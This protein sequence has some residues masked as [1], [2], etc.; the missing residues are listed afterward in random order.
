MFAIWFLKRLNNIIC[1][2]WFSELIFQ[3]LISISRDCQQDKIKNDMFFQRHGCRDFLNLSGSTNV[4][5]AS[6]GVIKCSTGESLS[7]QHTDHRTFIE[8]F[9]R[10]MTSTSFPAVYFQFPISLL[11]F[12]CECTCATLLSVSMSSKPGN[13]GMDETYVVTVLSFPSW[14]NENKNNAEIKHRYLY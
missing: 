11:L 13:G 7:Q 5:K 10:S 9:R 2:S 14:V 12:R 3:N 4:Q 1:K 6:I 8:D